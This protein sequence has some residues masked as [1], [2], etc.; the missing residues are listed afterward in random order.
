[1]GF[2]VDG[3]VL[4]WL[5]LSGWEPLQS[6]LLSF[7]AAVTSTWMLNRVWTFQPTHGANLMRQEYVRYF[8]MQT[9]GA[10]IN[11][12]IFLLLLQWIPALER[13]PVI[14]L[15]LGAAAALAFNYT[16]S[17]RLVFRR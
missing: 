13:I 7:L 9:V 11:L 2:I 1:M 17:S 15:T 4:T 8:G 16:A 10:C 14:P 5:M 12:G 6:R 3:G